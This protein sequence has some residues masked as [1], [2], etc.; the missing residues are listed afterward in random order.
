MPLHKV[1]KHHLFDTRL[2]QG[3]QHLLDVAKENTIGPNDQDALI[4]EG[5]SIRI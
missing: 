2:T 1:G 4:L 5:E 3:R